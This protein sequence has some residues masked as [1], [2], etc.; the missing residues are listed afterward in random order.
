M[1]TIVSWSGRDSSAWCPIGHA[2][3]RRP[4]LAQ[5]GPVSCR[6]V[7]WDTDPVRCVPLCLRRL[8]NT[9]HVVAWS[10]GGH[11]RHVFPASLTPASLTGSLPCPLAPPCLVSD[12]MEREVAEALGQARLDPLLHGAADGS[13]GVGQAGQPRL[14]RALHQPLHRMP[15]DRGSAEVSFEGPSPQP[16][17]ENAAAR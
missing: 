2:S 17:R 1:H 4:M 7:G 3:W 5:R 14:H 15:G 11:M 9:A 16:C 6:V 8:P 13:H 12:G 10:P